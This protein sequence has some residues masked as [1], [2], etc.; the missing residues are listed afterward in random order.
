MLYCSGF[1][2]NFLLMFLNEFVQE[3][4]ALAAS[5]VAFMLQA[6]QRRGLHFTLA[7]GPPVT[8][9]QEPLQ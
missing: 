7:A 6:G 8:A 9:H 5:E 3:A 1:F 2:F 4:A